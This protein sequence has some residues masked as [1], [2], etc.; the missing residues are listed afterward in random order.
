MS[1]IEKIEQFLAKLAKVPHD[2]ALHF[3]FGFL[4]FNFF[5]IFFGNI[6]ALIIITIIAIIKEIYDHYVPYHEMSIMDIIY[7]VVPG[8]IQTLI[9]FL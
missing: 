7:G 2:K 8:V 6:L 9:G 1:I 3:M 4:I 5:T